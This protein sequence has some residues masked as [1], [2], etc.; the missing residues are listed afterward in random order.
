MDM[1]I[2]D[3]INKEFTKPDLLNQVYIQNEPY[4]HIVMDN[5]IKEDLLL[6]VLD[7][8]PDLSKLDAKVEFKNEREIKY[9]SIGFKDIQK[10]A[11]ELITFLN[12][13]I[14]LTYLQNLTGIEETLISDPYLAG[15]GYHEIKQGGVL[16]VHADFNKHP[17]LDLDRRLNLLLYLNHDWNNDW[18]GSL[19]LY[20][21][22]NLTEPALSISPNFNRCVIFSTTSHTYHGHPD[23]LK[24]PENISRKS[25]ALYYFSTG[26]PKSEITGEHSTV[27]VKT[28]GESFSLWWRGWKHLIVDLTP[29]LLFRLARNTLK[30]LK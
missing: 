14:F 5:F 8:F 19:E 26:R 13:D 25:I 2:S 20:D 30:R 27:W 16:K 7:E 11:L 12:S 29:P 6:K 9:A 1:K 21:K 23:T 28:K 10:K 24:C 17:G 3:F 4:P 15:A 22:N 18:G